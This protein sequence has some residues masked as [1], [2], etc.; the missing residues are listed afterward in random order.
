MTARR[1][2]GAL[3]AGATTLLLLGGTIGAPMV[4]ADTGSGYRSNF[5]SRFFNPG[6]SG[7]SGGSS[8]S[9]GSSGAASGTCTDVQLVFARGTGELPGLGIVGTPLASALGTAL[10][11]KSVSSYAV[12]YAADFA[13]TS[14]GPGATDM[15]SHIKTVAATCPKTQFVIGGYSQGGSVT[16]IAMGIQ[17]GTTAGTAIPA[18]LTNRVAA[19]VVYGNPLGMLRRTI[20]E[21]SASYGPKAKEFCNTGDPVCGGGANV[22]AHLLYATNGSV[23]QG[24]SFA[25]GKISNS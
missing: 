13:Q 4:F 16:D 2:R 7:G 25:A 18:D 5:W 14:A 1:R 8:G 21:S 3:V 12:D 24:A 10:P 6:G 15:A 11:G 19:V 17:F 23:E 9:S 22:A 20:A